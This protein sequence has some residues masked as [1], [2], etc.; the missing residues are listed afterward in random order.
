[1]E[2]QIETTEM[3][4]GELEAVN[5]GAVTTGFGVR[6]DQQITLQ[7]QLTKAFASGNPYIYYGY[8]G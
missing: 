4:D 7:H 5:G 3:T 8:F 2:R 1:M 6:T